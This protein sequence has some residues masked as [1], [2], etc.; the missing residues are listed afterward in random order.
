[1][2][3]GPR[4]AGL[5][6][7]V[8]A[9]THS[10]FAC[11][12]LPVASFVAPPRT[13]ADITA[14]LDQ[15]K[16]DPSVAVGLRSRADAEPKAGLNRGELAKFH[17]QR[18]Q[19]RSLLGESNNAIAD[20]EQAV[21]LGR[22]SLSPGDFMR[23]VQGLGIQHSFAGDPKKALEVFLRMVREADA[24]G[25][26]GWLFNGYRH[27]AD[28]YA[29]VGDFNQAEAYVRKNNAL[30]GEAR[31]WKTYIGF[32]R[33]SWH[34]DVERGN[35]RMFE[36]RGQFREAEAAYKRA[37]A[38]GRESEALVETYEDG[39]R[40][41]VD[42][43]AV[44]TDAAI[45]NQGRMKARQGRHAEGEADTRR[46]LLGR[47]KTGGKYNV[48]TGRFI[49]L[50]SN[51]LIEQGRFTEA[52]LLTRTRI[53][54]NRTLGVAKDSRNAVNT[55]NQLASNLNLQGRWTEAAKVYAELD[56]AIST[57]PQARR[58]AITLNSNQ[59]TTLYATNNL[60]A[61]ISAAE[62]LVE[63]QRTRL[64]ERHLDTA[65]ARGLFAIGLARAGRDQDAAREFKLAVPILDDDFARYRFG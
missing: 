18:C 12:Q 57:W 39:M 10:P 52:E 56:E 25:T 36:L 53:E 24:K 59:I 46:A 65:L 37:E 32:R 22:G 19:A 8:Y 58:E 33:A 35:A 45:A 20:C 21:E 47:L 6:A 23:L 2:F 38:F 43:L 26:R 62:R 17:Y 44:A 40:P 29:A 27:I 11:A 55:R 49:G 64:G 28:F 13:I 61:G 16:P 41:P 5:L 63:R 15:E 51:I 50:L 3:G 42:Q 34:A 48:V 1:M 14:I 4:V 54:I 60:S 31:G 9:V 7:V 30:L